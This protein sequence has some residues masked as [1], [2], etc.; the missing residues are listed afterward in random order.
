M[1]SR[2]TTKLTAPVPPEDEVTEAN[3][4][5]VETTEAPKRRGAPV[6]LLGKA[7]REFEVANRKYDKLVAKRDKL[8]DELGDVQAELDALVATRDN[9][10]EA[11]EKAL[12]D[13]S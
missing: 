1:T 7:G 4:A 6:S 2:K 10:R 12:S 13:A 9:A 8:A 5:T 3:D 11:L